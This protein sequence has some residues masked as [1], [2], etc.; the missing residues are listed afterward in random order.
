MGRD[1]ELPHLEMQCGFARCSFARELDRKLAVVHRL[2]LWLSTSRKVDGLWIGSWE[3]KPQ[4]GLRRVEDA[5]RLIKQHDSLHYSHVI[6]NLERIWLHL[7]PNALKH[8]DRSLNACVLDERFV[9][10]ETTTLERIASTI[11]HEATHA[12]LARWGISY[13]DEKTR[14]RIEAICL[15]RE[16]NIIAKLPNCKP[17]REQIARTLE[18]CDSNHNYFSDVSFQ[19]RNDQ[20][21][22]EALRYLGTPDWLIRLVL[23]VRAVIFRVHRFVHRFAGRPSLQA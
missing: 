13:G 9:L 11:V 5:L 6:H 22:V 1:E 14:P 12:R 17:L 3:S 2:A 23:N 16:L 19:R 20:G 15:R 4:P 8:Y 18:W 7:V 21:Y 10:L